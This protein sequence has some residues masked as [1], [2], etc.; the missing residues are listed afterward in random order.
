MRQLLRWNRAAG[1]VHALLYS[2]INCPLCLGGGKGNNRG[3]GCMLARA[4]SGGEDARKIQCVIGIRK[5][6]SYIIS[7]VGKL[8]NEQGD[9]CMSVHD[10]LCHSR[11][12]DSWARV[13]GLRWTISG[14]VAGTMRD[15]IRI[16]TS[17]AGYGSDGGRTRGNS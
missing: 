16:E 10:W 15:R 3:T 9:T 1:V 8:G 13:V 2:A 11:W 4:R 5:S 6:L 12:I 17:G 7:P 14:R